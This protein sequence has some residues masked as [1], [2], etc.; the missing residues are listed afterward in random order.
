M[1][2][3]PNAKINLGLYVTGV[4]PDGYHDI[5]TLFVPVPTLRD[6]LEVVPSDR[7]EVRVFNLDIADSLCTKA[8]R[9]LEKDFGIPPVAINLYKNIPAGAGLGGGSSDAAFTLKA[10]DRIFS[11]GLDDSTLA[12]YASQIGSDCP[13]FIYNTPM[14]A[15]GCG[16]ILKPHELPL[17]NYEI[18]VFPQK[19]FVSTREAYSGVT[20]RKP[21]IPLA[22]A[23]EQPV[24]EWKN[25]LFNDFEESVF[26]KYPELAAAKQRLY[27]EGA[28]YAAMSGSGSSIFGIF[29]K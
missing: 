15:S 2:I 9:L 18:K 1:I 28:V 19:V 29:G 26:A 21:E 5:E 6:I 22:R 11:L 20:P 10:L 4:R 12:G 8:F 25:V 13:F 14:T 7:F 17:D 27:E 16:D 23:L 24:E 3:Y